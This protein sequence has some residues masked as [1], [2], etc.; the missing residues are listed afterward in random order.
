LYQ[1]FFLSKKEKQRKKDKQQRLV[2]ALIASGHIFSITTLEYVHNYAVDII[3]LT[4]YNVR[5]I[6]R[7]GL[8]C[9]NI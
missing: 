4:A 1:Q 8:L 5:R 6:Y 7:E 3:R 2:A 9:L